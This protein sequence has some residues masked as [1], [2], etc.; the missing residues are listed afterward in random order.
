MHYVCLK[1]EDSQ[2]TVLE[3]L[4]YYEVFTLK[5]CCTCS[6]LMY[7]HSCV[8]DVPISLPSFIGKSI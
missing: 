4:M 8:V 7:F 3:P 6:L 1:K 5:A 2:L